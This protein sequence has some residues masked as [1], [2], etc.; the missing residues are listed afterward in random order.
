[1]NSPYWFEVAVVF[2]LG[3]IGGICFEAFAAET[4][5]LWRIVKLLVGAALAVTVSALFG[6]IGFFVLLTLVL[7]IVGIVHAWWL[8]RHGVNGWTAE[9]RERY[10][11]L[12]GRK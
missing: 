1:M 5:K 4:P 9:P 11:A 3:S 7:G 10:R 12:R 8:P 6:R 2:G